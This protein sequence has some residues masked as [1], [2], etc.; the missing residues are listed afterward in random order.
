MRCV[1]G[2]VQ[3]VLARWRGRTYC[4]S[5]DL[6]SEMGGRQWG[7][8]SGRHVASV[9]SRA[10]VFRDV[11]R[12]KNMTGHVRMIR[13]VWRLAIA[14]CL[15]SDRGVIDH[16]KLVQTGRRRDD[17]SI[18]AISSMELFISC[19]PNRVYELL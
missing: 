8:D 9:T 2:V 4:C 18:F 13:V 11:G 16:E 17:L 14:G 7:I 6:A 5:L 19:K 12:N 10:E 1:S 15:G 3:H